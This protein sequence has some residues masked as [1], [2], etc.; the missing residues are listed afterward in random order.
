MVVIMTLIHKKV[1]PIRV[2]RANER[3]IAR[4]TVIAHNI[5]QRKQFI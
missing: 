4:L 3:L 2:R 1:W 5:T